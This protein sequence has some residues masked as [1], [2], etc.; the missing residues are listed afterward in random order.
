MSVSVEK[1]DK[2]YTYERKLKKMANNNPSRS[3]RIKEFINTTGGFLAFIAIIGAAIFYV[4]ATLT[5]H[6][7][8]I[9]HLDEK[10]E[11]LEEDYNKI[12]EQTQNSAK[13]AEKDH[14]ILLNLSASVKNEVVY[15]VEFLN[16][17]FARTITVNDEEFLSKLDLQDSYIVAKDW[18]GDT[19][20]TVSDFYNV[21]IITSYNEGDNEVYFYGRYNENGNWNGTCILNVYKGNNLVSIFEGVY[22]NGALYRYR[23]A[24]D[25][26]DGTW[27]I[28]DRINQGEYTIGETYTCS[29]TSDYVKEFTKENVKE[30]QITSVENF[31]ASRNEKILSYYNGRTAK[32][33]YNDDTGDAYL[34]KYDDTGNVRYLYKGIMK[35]GHGNDNRKNADSW[36]FIWGDANDGYHYHEGKFENSHPRK[37]AKDWKYPK[38][39]DFINSIINPNDFK[40]PLTGLIEE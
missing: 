25:E 3:D 29:K 19:T 31:W 13:L 37:T 16:D 39:Q 34:V 1:Y 27:V 7:N 20:Y 32:G 36:A 12:N 35:D 6:G 21:P 30:K 40:C 38:D 15:N 14:E 33:Y 9:E 26:G 24:A 2:M 17:D 22:Q 5:N 11:Q 18:N 8:Q 4:V 28:T 10:I 23:R